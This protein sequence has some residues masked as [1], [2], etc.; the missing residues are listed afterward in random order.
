MDDL[1]SRTMLTA[2]IV[3]AWDEKGGKNL[4]RNAAQ[5]AAGVASRGT[6]KQGPAG[7]MSSARAAAR[8]ADHAWLVEHG[9]I[10]AD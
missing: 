1:A 4:A 8:E 5:L 7:L 2:H 3:G 6:T 9:V 10:D